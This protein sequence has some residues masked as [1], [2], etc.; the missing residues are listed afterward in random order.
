MNKQEMILPLQFISSTQ[1]DAFHD[2]R[3]YEWKILFAVLSFD[4]LT[5][6][7]KLKLDL[8]LSRLTILI[9]IA[10]LG[11]AIISS[12]FLRF[13]HQAHH[14]NKTFAHRAEDAILNILKEQQPSSEQ[15]ELYLDPEPFFSKRAF[16]NV[17]KGGAWA[18]FW[19]TVIL[20][21]FA[22][23]SAFLVTQ[24]IH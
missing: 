5:A 2:R 21:M 19:Q 6:G 15:L 20:T 12:I 10:Y 17:G 3:S 22:I 16:F 23:A 11:L 13:V 8:D 24:E 7:A 4:V 1:R 14:W 9:W 18:W